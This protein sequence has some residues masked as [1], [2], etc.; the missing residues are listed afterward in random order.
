AGQNGEVALI[1]DRTAEALNVAR[2]GRLLFRRAAAL[3]LGDGG[4][5]NRYRQQ[6]ECKEKF[7]HHL[8]SS[9]KWEIRHKARRERIA[10]AANRE[11]SEAL[12]IAAKFAAAR[13]KLLEPIRE[14]N[15]LIYMTHLLPYL[16]C[17]GRL[18]EA[19]EDSYM[20][21]CESWRHHRRFDF[22]GSENAVRRRY[23]GL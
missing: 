23:R 13:S 17:H 22:A 18:Q 12:V 7:T 10:G 15:R 16:F 3:L 8:P 6:C 2:T 4:G 19:P 21:Q 9:W 1:D 11:R 14:Y 5:R 20:E